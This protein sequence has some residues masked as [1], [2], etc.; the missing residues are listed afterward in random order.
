MDDGEAEDGKHRKLFEPLD[1]GVW[2]RVHSDTMRSLDQQYPPVGFNRALQAAF[3][4]GAP[5]E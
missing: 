2:I 3:R 4:A 1:S 5:P